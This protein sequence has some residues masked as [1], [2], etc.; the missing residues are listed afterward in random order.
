MELN[1]TEIDDLDNGQK[2][3]YNYWDKQESNNNKLSENNNSSIKNKKNK[4]T[5]DDILTNMNLVVNNNGVLQF[6]CPVTQE[7]TYPS[8][9]TYRPIHQQQTKPLEP[10]IKNS[11]IFNKYF[12]NYKD[13]TAP[14]QDSNIRVPKTIEEYKT[15]LLEDKI[16]RIQEQRRIAQIKP[17]KLL[18]TNIGTIQ[19]TKNGLRQ[20]GF[21]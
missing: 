5:F 6:M 11:T 9:Y 17:K 12:K 16:K 4:V 14:Q 20:M 18:F 2:T 7:P 13:P 8:T 21:N 10:E 15:M 1:F 19:A 3:I